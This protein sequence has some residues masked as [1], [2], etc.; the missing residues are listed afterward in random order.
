[1]ALAQVKIDATEERL[2]TLDMPQEGWSTA[3]RKD[4]LM[5]L[6]SMGLPSRRDE[7]WKYTRP[8]TLV[9]PKALDAA[10]LQTDEVPV[11]DGLERLKIVFVDGVFSADESD[12]LVLEGVAIERLADA[13]ADIHWAKGLYGVFGK[14]GSKPC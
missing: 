5:R 8:D 7:Y 14:Q 12:D 1:M 6:R 11:F 9:Q 13:T 10:V 2:N 4:A 3:A